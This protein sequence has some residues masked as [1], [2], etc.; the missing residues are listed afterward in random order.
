MGADA[1]LWSQLEHP[2]E[3]VNATR[4]DCVEDA[5]QI[6]RGVHLERGLVLR[7]LRNAR[8][9]AFRGRAHDAEYPNNLIFVGGAGEQGSAGIHFSHDAPRRPDVNTRIISPTTEQDVWRAVPQGDDF[10]REGVDRDAK[11]T[12]QTE[13]T[14][15]QAPFAINEQVL[16]LEIAMQHPV[17][18]AKIDALEE[19][20]HERLDRRGLERAALTVG[21]HV[22]LQVAVHVLKHEHQLV[23]GVNNIVKSN[24]ILVLELLHKRDFPDRRRRRSLFG[25][26]VD[27]LERNEL[28][29]LA[30]SAFEHLS[31]RH[32]R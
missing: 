9:C 12:G 26:E 7:Q 25:V 8:P 24:D 20:V 19:L 30:V 28:A 29:R 27:L 5:S 15:L 32:V 17:L 6:L 22:S 16:R 13:I 18:V 4:V 21:I 31:G 23:L 14:Q 11:G 2:L 10:V 1:E 3:Q